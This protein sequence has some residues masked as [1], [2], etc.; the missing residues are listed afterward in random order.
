MAVML[1]D[2][3]EKAGVSPTTVSLVLNPHSKHR[4]SQ[5]TQ[6]KVFQVAE[7]LG[8]HPE[9]KTA[10][11]PQK[12]ETV[13]SDLPFAIG[14]VVSNI[15]NPFF[16]ELASVVE[17]IAS[18]YGYNIIL[19]N[20]KNSTEKEAEILEILSRR[21]VNG[22]ILAPVDSEGSNLQKIL[23]GNIPVVFVDRSVEKVEASA[24][25]LDNA[26][27]AYMATRHLLQLGHTKIGIVT[28][29]QN[30]PV[31][32]ERLQG[33]IRALQEGNIPIDKSLIQDGEFAI[34][35][36]KAAM[37]T[38]LNLP[39]PPSAVFSCAGYMTAG[40][41]Q[42]IRTRRLNI[43]KDLSLITFDDHIWMQL[44]EPPLTVIAQPI[45]EIG[46]EATQLIVQLIQGWR[47]K[48]P[49]KIILE[50][51]LIL[52]ESCTCHSSN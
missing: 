36:G 1:K 11:K 52:R 6:Q 17:D 34:E 39:S 3:A 45:A 37:K 44:L 13:V 25:V 19:C 27:G 33:Y 50:P 29:P 14:L 20:T 51:T 21:K 30:I 23:K 9:D 5:K 18:H 7:E 10:P 40:I 43:P 24:V 47:K 41:L 22:L 38:L 8:Y 16:T 12:S 15:T 42:E 26:R 46:K 31:G 2:I 48:K 4:I 28:G 35:G 49:Q 32:K